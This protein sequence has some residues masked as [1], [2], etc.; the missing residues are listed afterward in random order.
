MEE[1]IVWLKEAGPAGTVYADVLFAQGVD[2]CGKYS[3]NAALQTQFRVLSPTA[4]HKKLL[5]NTLK[6]TADLLEKAADNAEKKSSVNRPSRAKASRTGEGTQKPTQ[7][8]GKGK[9]TRK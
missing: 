7:N 2:L 4:F 6:R 3:K 1:L 9:A 5:R 8:R